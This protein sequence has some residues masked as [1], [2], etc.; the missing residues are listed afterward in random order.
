MAMPTGGNATQVTTGVIAG[1]VSTILWWVVA[2]FTGIE[3]SAEVV[4]ASV[5][6]VTAIAQ[7]YA[8]VPE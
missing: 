6:L 8:P 3:P 2:T 5:V 1:A 7:Y 4:A